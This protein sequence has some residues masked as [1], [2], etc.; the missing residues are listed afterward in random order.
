MKL[1]HLTAF[2]LTALTIIP[3][4]AGQPSAGKT[5]TAPPAEKKDW[6]AELRIDGWLPQM[7]VGISDTSA[8]LNKNVFLSL[9]DILS[10]LDWLVPVG[11]DFRYKRF[12]FMPDL[13]AAKLS[14]SGAS[15]GGT[16]LS[17]GVPLYSGTNLDMTMVV[18]N[19]V[20]Y[21]RIVDRESLTIDILGGARYLS[22]DQ[23]L[24][25]SGGARGTTRGPLTV[26]TNVEVW[27]G[28]GGLRYKQNFNDRLF[29]SFYGDIGAGASKLTWQVW[30]G[31]G[32]QLSKHVSVMAGYRYLTWDGGK[33]SRDITVT[34]GGPTL[35]LHWAF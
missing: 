26:N 20:G 32:Y 34:A 8:G 10:H 1:T 11:G 24:T 19:L 28:V 25:L 3:A 31:L 29:L 16:A 27:N 30:T 6:S 9:G 7:N 4:Q 15:P 13:Y 22:V 12:G 5:V 17:G 2:C 33:A 18:L 21:C 35:D 23:D 14:G